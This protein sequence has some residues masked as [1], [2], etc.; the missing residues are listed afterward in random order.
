M[1]RCFEL[2]TYDEL[3]AAI[4]RETNNFSPGFSYTMRQD[5]TRAPHPW[6]LEVDDGAPPPRQE[7]IASKECSCAPVV[8]E[9]FRDP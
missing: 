6:L 8:V 4:K 3:Q 9:D 7:H 5:Y 2:D 1:K